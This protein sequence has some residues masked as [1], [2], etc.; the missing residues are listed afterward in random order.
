MKLFPSSPSP[1]VLWLSTI[2]ASLAVLIL[3]I[4][5]Y[6][7]QPQA[8]A[9]TFS[10]DSISNLQTPESPPSAKPQM[11]E[12]A[13]EAVA[14][15]PSEAPLGAKTQ[16]PD[17]AP[18]TGVP[19]SALPPEMNATSLQVAKDPGS[20]RVPILIYH[21]IRN[22]VHSKDIVRYQMNVPPAIFE[23]Q[24]Q[25]LIDDGDHFV[26]LSDLADALDGKVA[27]PAKPVVITFDDGLEDLYS[28][29]FPILKKL[30][31][32]VTAFLITNYLDHKY[33]LKSS[34]VKEMAQSG[35][36]E[37]GSHTI[38]HPRLDLLT[39]EKAKAQIADSKTILEKDFGSPVSSFAYPH[40]LFN[41]NTPKLVQDAGYRVAVSTVYGAKANPK[42]RYFLPRINVG[43]RIGKKLL[44]FL[45]IFK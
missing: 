19:A 23:A 17:P 22:S 36:V 37:I 42:N 21:Y 10:S 3:A 18:E 27:L 34:E 8:I 33:Y 29:V 9:P 40:G 43:E 30:Q 11:P 44:D 28:T 12:A 26:T 24:L 35:L 45:A 13:P 20:L 32:K 39:D 2:A 41:K 6:F 25:T 38:S 1:R 4:H 7:G 14:P 16:M 5:F 31:A 15:I